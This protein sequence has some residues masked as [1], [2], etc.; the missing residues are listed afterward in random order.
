MVYYHK[1]MQQDNN[2]EFIIAMIKEV[3]DH[4]VNKHWL[5]IN[6]SDISQGKKVFPLV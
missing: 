4:I 2:N 6:K 1:A 3:N 5:L